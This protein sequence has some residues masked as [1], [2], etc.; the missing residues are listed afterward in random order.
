MGELVERPCSPADGQ[1]SVGTVDIIDLKFTDRAPAGG[2]HG[3][4]GDDQPI[5]CAH[6]C[7][8]GALNLVELQRLDEP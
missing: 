8:D 6:G 2:V 1:A 5:C 7:P 3:G 4:Q